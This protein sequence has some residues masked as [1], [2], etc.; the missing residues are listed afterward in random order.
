MEKKVILKS[1]E[2]GER[3]FTPSHAERLLAFQ[4]KHGH[5]H[6]T[7]KPTKKAKPETDELKP[8]TNE[9]NGATDTGNI[10]SSEEH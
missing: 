9:A 8:Q 7:A 2:L 3:E 6:W 5:S 4:K 1:E 10:S